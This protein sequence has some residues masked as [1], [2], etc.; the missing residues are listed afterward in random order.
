MR[1]PAP[2]PGMLVEHDTAG[3]LWVILGMTPT[4]DHVRAFNLDSGRAQLLARTYVS[5][6]ARAL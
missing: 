2:T 1:S 3:T 6:F 4:G 5:N